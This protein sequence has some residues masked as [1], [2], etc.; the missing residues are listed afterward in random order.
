MKF[1]KM[2]KVWYAIEWTINVGKKKHHEKKNQQIK[3]K[4]LDRLA[5]WH[6]KGKATDKE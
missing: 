3:R 1:H 5:I 6:I 2:M 4:Y